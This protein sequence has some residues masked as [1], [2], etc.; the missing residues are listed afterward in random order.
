MRIL[1]A[2]RL[3]HCWVDWFAALRSSAPGCTAMRGSPARKAAAVGSITKTGQR[4]IVLATLLGE[5]G[6]QS[7]A[8]AAVHVAVTF[9]RSTYTQQTAMLQAA[10]ALHEGMKQPT[11][12]DYV[13]SSPQLDEQPDS[14][15]CCHNST[16]G[17]TILLIK[18]AIQATHMYGITGCSLRMAAT[19]SMTGRMPS[20]DPHWPKQTT[21]CTQERHIRG[22]MVSL[23][24]VRSTT[25]RRHEA[26]PQNQQ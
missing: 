20:A 25:C 14:C 18:T 8:H 26:G 3:H 23:Y 6:D 19:L 17:L 24:F 22:L 15:Y 4:V 9:D 2:V 10:T 13:A 12:L 11:T 21:S 16:A 1:R 7:H 5:A